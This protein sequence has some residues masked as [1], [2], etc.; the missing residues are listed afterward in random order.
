MKMHGLILLAVVA[1]AGCAA[2][3]KV[4]PPPATVEQSGGKEREE[5]VSKATAAPPVE[6]AESTLRLPGQDRVYPSEDPRNRP[7][8]LT[9]G[10]GER[11]VVEPGTPAE[12]RAAVEPGAPAGP[13][14]QVAPATHDQPI[15]PD[16]EDE[17]AP[18]PVR[19][20]DARYRVQLLASMGR[21]TAMALREEMAGVLAIPVFVEH[22][23]GI[24]KVRAGDFRERV[25]A[26]ALRRRIVGLGYA[27]AFVVEVLGR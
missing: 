17:F 18:P 4:L 2:K 15:I 13:G 12:P 14:A 8:T 19:S 1:T 6:E 9:I 24:W 10:G 26:E 23:P 21:A 5:E 20:G 11:R 7:G 3:G 22:E 27:D 25:E 16:P